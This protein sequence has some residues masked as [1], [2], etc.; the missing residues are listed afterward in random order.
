[1]ENDS[2]G[3]PRVRVLLPATVE[4]VVEFHWSGAVPAAAP[5]ER[6]VK[7]G[8]SV[9]LAAGARVLN[10]EDPQ[11]ALQTPALKSDR[12]TGKA[13]GTPGHRTVFA[14]V[15]QGDMEWWQPLA[16]RIDEARPAPSLV[17]TT[18]WNQPSK[19]KHEPLALDGLFNEDL[20]LL[21]QR[22]A[23][24]YPRYGNHHGQHQ[25]IPGVFEVIQS[26]A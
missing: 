14:K 1:L 3:T 17:F 9:T 10:I 6:V 4:S 2:V 18:D 24:A 8:K 12:L 19:G 16:L 23:P 13:V 5:A 22:G 21:F 11:G 20:N 26:Q 15:R 7:Q 25:R